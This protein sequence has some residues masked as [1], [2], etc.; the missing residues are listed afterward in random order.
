MPSRRL[1]KWFTTLRQLQALADNSQLTFDLLTDLAASQTQGSTITRI[2]MSIW[3]RND[4]VSNEKTMD[5]GI[6]LVDGE[7]AVAGAF[8]DADVEDERV[9]WMGR[10]RMHAYTS[11]LFVVQPHTMMERDLG[12]SRV[13]RNEFQQLRLILNSDTNGTGGLF[14]TF[15]TRVLVR[16]P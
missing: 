9:D 15:I 8:P 13:I 3:I 14:V 10:G 4:V 2:L 5:W 1:V 12:A 11:S 16:M 7:A 6:V